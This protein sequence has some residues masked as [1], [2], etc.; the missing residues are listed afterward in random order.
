MGRVLI[1]TCSWTDRSLIQAGTFYPAKSM[2]AEERLRYYASVFPLVEVD[3][4]YYALPSARNAA[5]WVERTPDD[6]IFDVKAF[7]LMS[8]HW[9]TPEALPSD[10]R[11]LT[12]GDSDRFYW[13]KASDKL[14]TEVVR[15]FRE[16]LTPLH[17]AGKLGL[18]LLQLPP[19]AVPR[20]ETFDHILAMRE[21]LAPYRLAVEL[22]NNAWTEGGRRE[23]TAGFLRRHGLVYVAVDEPQGYRSSMPSIVDVTSQQDAYV[24]FHGRNTETW[25]ARRKTSGERFDWRY[26][27]AELA[28]WLPRIAFLRERVERVHVLFNTNNDDQGPFN[29]LKL[30]RMLDGDGVRMDEPAFEAEVRRRLSEP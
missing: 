3:S 1:G 11:L 19:W 23:E 17:E 2:S 7:R 13:E 16:A 29:A 27:D 22:R 20:A 9:T 12:P 28:E 18:V 24:R 26:S 8:L 6:F 25:E 14:R 4:S 15:R 30:S 5:L 10:L 21:A